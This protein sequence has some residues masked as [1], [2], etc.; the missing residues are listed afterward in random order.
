MH[1]ISTGEGEKRRR[2]NACLG[3]Q[4][5]LETGQEAYFINQK[6]QNDYKVYLNV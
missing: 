5:L 1:S 2:E 6:T 3:I 4:I